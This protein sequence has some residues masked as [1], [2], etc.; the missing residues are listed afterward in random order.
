[1]EYSDRIIVELISI[2]FDILTF[3]GLIIFILV[4]LFPIA[5][6][7]DGKYIQNEELAWQPNL[8]LYVSGGVLGI[9]IP[10]LQQVIAIIY[11]YNRYKYSNAS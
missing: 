2:S 9:G 5:I 11:L 4:L 6:Y 1:M 7:E 10:L 8:V 3:G